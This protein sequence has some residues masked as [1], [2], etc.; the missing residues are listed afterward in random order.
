MK[1]LIPAVTALFLLMTGAIFAQSQKI[2]GN[3]NVVKQSRNTGDFNGISLAGD[4]KVKLSLGSNTAVQ[5]ETD[6]NLQDYIITEVKNGSLYIST[7]N[8]YDVRSK[9]DVVVY[10]SVKKIEDVQISGSGSLKS[11]ELIPSG[12][13]F[14]VAV[15]GSGDCKMMVSADKTNAN[16]SGSGSIVLAGTTG[17]LDVKIAGSGNY[18]GF[19]MTSK[20]AKISISGSGDAET[21]VSEK[22]DAAISGSGNVLYKGNAEA[23]IKTVGSGTLKKQ[24]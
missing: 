2:E 13:N 10:V 6:E 4:M 17:Q 18:K 11:D 20:N 15:S 9:K 24:D 21:N 5:V 12:G 1:K 22:L 16:I 19:D 8:H 3:G 23:S 7:K 14:E